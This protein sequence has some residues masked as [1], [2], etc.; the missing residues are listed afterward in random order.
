MVSI[1]E[2]GIGLSCPIVL[3]E[4]CPSHLHSQSLEPLVGKTELMHYKQCAEGT[5]IKK[6]CTGNVQCRVFTRLHLCKNT[7]CSE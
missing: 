5:Q 7:V 3:E 1:S 2:F 4:I 6:A